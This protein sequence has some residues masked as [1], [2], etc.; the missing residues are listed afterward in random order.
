MRQFR[1]HVE[2]SDLIYKLY[3]VQTVIKTAKFIFILCCTANFVN[4]ISFEHVCKPKVEHLVLLRGVRAHPQHGVHAE[5]AAHQLH[6]HYLVCMVLSASYLFLVI[7]DS[8]KEYSF[9]KVREE[10]SFSDI[11]D[12]K[13]DFA[14]LLHMVDQY[15]QLYSKRFGVFLSEVSENK[16]REISLNHEWTFEN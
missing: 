13:N 8:L 7:Q 1:A 9:E 5:K 4:A 16:L 15:D 3:V 6:I 11:P 10:S 14:F 12:V 2:D